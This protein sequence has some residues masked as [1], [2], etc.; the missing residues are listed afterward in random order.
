[1]LFDTS[2]EYTRILSENYS[3]NTCSFDLNTKRSKRFFFSLFA[4]IGAIIAKVC[5]Y[6]NSN[7]KKN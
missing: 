1:M 7:L 2:F 6:I 5:K 3:K 4:A